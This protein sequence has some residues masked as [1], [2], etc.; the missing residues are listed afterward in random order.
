MNGGLRF[1]LERMSNWERHHTETDRLAKS[2]SL[3]WMV[4]YIN[5]VVIILLTSSSYEKL[6]KF[7]AWVPIFSGEYHDFEAEWFKEIGYAI[8]I[9][10]FIMSIFPLMNLGFMGLT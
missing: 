2:V 3:M 1:I 5:T 7:E 8:I 9:S 4:Q 10:V 6:V